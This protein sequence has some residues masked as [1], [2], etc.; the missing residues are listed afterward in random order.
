MEN[1]TLERMNIQL[2]FLKR[3]RNNLVIDADTHI[4]ELENLPPDL[5]EKY[6]QSRNYYHG[7]PI[8]AEDLL[9]EMEMAGVDMSLVWQNPAVT[10]YEK[11]KEVNFQQLLKANRY[12]AEMAGKYP[13]KLIPAGWTDP[14]AL[15]LEKALELTEYCIQELGFPIVKMNPAQNAYPIDSDEVIGVVEK[16]Q[17]HKAMAAFHYGADTLYTPAEGLEKIAKSFPE[18]RIIGV[19][20]G[21]G[22]AGYLEGEALYLKT[23]EM[24]LT[25]KN[26]FF[27]QSAKRDTHIESDFITYTLAGEPHNRQIACASDAPYG[28]QTW[29]FGGYRLMFASLV[30]AEHHTDSRVRENPELFNTDMIKN[31]MGRKFEELVIGGYESM[32]RP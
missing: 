24:G 8:S 12:I 30:N 14:R 13:E 20:M 10:P 1:S 22:G 5:L 32:R 18:T 11:D 17:E 9:A 4:T 23:R 16:I 6:R 3:N 2:D 31:Y 19:H 26:L 25:N 27:I 21:G 29:N 15:G 28:R 7:K